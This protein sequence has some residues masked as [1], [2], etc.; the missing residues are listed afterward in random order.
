MST[1]L[2]EVN[3]LEDL[4]YPMA[5]VDISSISGLGTKCT[6]PRQRI[7]KN[8]LIGFSWEHQKILLNQPVKFS[9]D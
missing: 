4:C 8:G 2:V 9:V 7:L 6:S 5:L 1:L 3:V